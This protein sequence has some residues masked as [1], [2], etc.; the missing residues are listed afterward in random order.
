VA[1]QRPKNRKQYLTSFTSVTAADGATLCKLLGTP[2][3]QTEEAAGCDING[4]FLVSVDRCSAE[5]AKLEAKR[6][7]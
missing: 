1:R 3:G 6:E 4:K 2:C 5:N 7:L